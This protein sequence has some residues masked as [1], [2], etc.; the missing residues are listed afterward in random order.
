VRVVAAR[1]NRSGL[2]IVGALLIMT[3]CFAVAKVHARSPGDCCGDM[4]G[5]NCYLEFP[6]KSCSINSN[7]RNQNFPTCC[8]AGGFCNGG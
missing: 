7:C 5:T 8:A 1:V 3:A 2:A 4:Q 6:Y